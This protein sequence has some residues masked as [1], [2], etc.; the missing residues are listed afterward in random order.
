[1]F[2]FLHIYKE[3]TKLLRVDLYCTLKLSIKNAIK[4]TVY[5]W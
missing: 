5:H 1:M 3:Q 2:T 4:Q